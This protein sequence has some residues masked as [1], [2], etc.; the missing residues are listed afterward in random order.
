[1]QWL[2]F[3]IRCVW[4]SVWASPSPPCLKGRCEIKEGAGLEVWECRVSRHTLQLTQNVSVGKLFKP[5]RRLCLIYKLRGSSEVISRVSVQF[6]LA[7]H[8]ALAFI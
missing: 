1:M 7:Q 5:L 6:L 2:A 8:T 3:L 4:A